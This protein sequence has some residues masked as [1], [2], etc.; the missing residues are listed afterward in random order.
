MD[1]EIATLRA[2]DQRDRHH[3][4]LRT[5]GI[6]EK[7]QEGTCLQNRNRLSNLRSAQ[8]KVEGKEKLGVWD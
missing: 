3:A 4:V 5:H 1:T 8:G 6:Y 2:A 7:L